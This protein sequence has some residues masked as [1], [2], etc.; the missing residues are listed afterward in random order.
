MKEKYI[1]NPQYKILNETQIIDKRNYRKYTISKEQYK[2]Q[3][4]FEKQPKYFSREL[5]EDDEEWKRILITFYRLLSQN[6]II[7]VSEQFDFK[8]VY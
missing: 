1:L 6:I 2:I 4:Y 7:K 5:C 8:V 3:K